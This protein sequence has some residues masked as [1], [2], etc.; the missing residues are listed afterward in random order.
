M[1]GKGLVSLDFELPLTSIMPMM[2]LQ[3]QKTAREF[4]AAKVNS[5]SVESS[6]FFEFGDKYSRFWVVVRGME[7]QDFF[8]GNI[9]NGLSLFI[10]SCLDGKNV[11]KKL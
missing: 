1:L 2:R 11:S 5:S 8:S 10:G 7:R 6:I 4:D 9:G 3:K